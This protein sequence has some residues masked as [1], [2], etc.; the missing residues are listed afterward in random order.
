M[1][2]RSKTKPIQQISKKYIRKYSQEVSLPIDRFIIAAQEEEDKHQ[3]L[4]ELFEYAHAPTEIEK[5]FPKK[6]STYKFDYD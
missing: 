4:S 1:G 3:Y 2:K 5:L 6:Y